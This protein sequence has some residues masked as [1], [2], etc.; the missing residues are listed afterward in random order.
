[1]GSAHAWLQT[2]LQLHCKESI[3]RGLRGGVLYFE[4]SGTHG[5]TG[6]TR[7]EDSRL[8]AC[9]SRRELCGRRGAHTQGYLSTS[10]SVSG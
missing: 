7:V 5:H 9:G 3:E 4:T 6:G 1:M 8:R 2:I 10:W